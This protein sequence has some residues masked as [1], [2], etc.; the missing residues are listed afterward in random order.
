MTRYHNIDGKKV[1]LSVEEETQADADDAAHALALPAIIRRDLMAER[2]YGPIGDQLD[3]IYWD[4][5]NGTTTFKDHVA[6][7]KADNPK[8]EE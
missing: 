3:M 7:V 5:V 4:Q 2:D 1:P 6:A 8:P